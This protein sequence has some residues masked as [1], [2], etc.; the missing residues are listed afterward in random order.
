SS[1]TCGALAAN[2]PIGSGEVESAHRHVIQERLKLAGAWWKPANAQS[3]PNLRVL[4]ANHGWQRY[5]DA[6]AA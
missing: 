1:S 5:W 6:A 2:L 3:M 4:R